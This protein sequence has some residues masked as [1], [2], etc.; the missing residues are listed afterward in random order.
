MKEMIL[1]SGAAGQIGSVLSQRLTR[2]YGID[3]VVNTDIRIP[4]NNSGIWDILD[5][6]NIEKYSQLIDKY[7]ITQIYH[8][9]ALL[10]ASGE[11]NPIFTWKINLNSYIELL[12]LLKTKKVH[13]L[14]Y[15]STI[16][17]FGKESPK[18]N[19]PQHTIMTPNSMYGITKTAGELLNNYYNHRYDL[20]IR[21]VRY[22]GIIGWQSM[23]GG[24]TTDYAVDI[25]YEALKRNT[26]V[27][28]LK[29]D[30]TLPMMYMDDAIDATISIMN[31]EKE[32][33]RIR[34]SYNIAAIS[35]S[36]EEIY[37]SIKKHF[38]QFKIEYKPDYRQKIAETWPQSIDDSAARNDWGWT[39]KFDLDSMTEDMF[40]NIK[41]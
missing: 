35:F 28:F 22:P 8:L 20:D 29:E 1:I 23:P 21:S 33:I 4:E 13:K 41:L 5:V 3:C 24:G 34:T 40:K 38:P 18:V 31:A 37:E 32:D 11:T 9:A 25:Y 17:A 27:C 15:P 16:A 6:T 2:E 14:F 7:K 10:S 26:F 19:T 12:E 39:H 36:P 30:T